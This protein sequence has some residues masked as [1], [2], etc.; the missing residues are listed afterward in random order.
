MSADPTAEHID[1]AHHITALQTESG[2]LHICQVCKEATFF[3]PP[4][5]PC[6]GP[7]VPAAALAAS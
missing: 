1:A 2:W 4:P 6:P 3:Q 7:V 5:L